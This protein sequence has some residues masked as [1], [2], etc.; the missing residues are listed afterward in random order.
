MKILN[1]GKTVIF[2]LFLSLAG[3]GSTQ[4]SLPDSYEIIFDGSQLSEQRVQEMSAEV[5]ANCPQY[6]N[7]EL[8]AIFRNDLTHFRII[9]ITHDEFPKSYRDFSSF[10][11]KNKCNPSMVRDVNIDPKQFNPLKYHFGFNR[12][13]ITYIRFDESNLFFVILP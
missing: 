7:A 8:V 9:I 11:M 6:N 3:I 5:F 2:F 4:N 13:E 12:N 1:L 10:S